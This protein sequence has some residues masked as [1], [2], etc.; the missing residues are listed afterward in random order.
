MTGNAVSMVLASISFVLTVI[1]G[2][3]L[4][5]I[6]RRLEIGDSIRIEAPDRHITKVGTPTMGGVMFILPVFLVTILLNA[7]PLIGLSGV[8]RS[9]LVPLAAM[10]GFALLGGVDDWR[11]LSQR[12]LGEGMRART[13]FLLQIILAAATAYA[14]RDVLNVPHLLL[15]GLNIE[16]DLGFWFFPIAIFIIVGSANA[17]NFTDGLDGLA[18]L[19]AATAFAAFGGIALLQGQSF[20]AQF[21]FTLVGALFGF[22]WFN[23]FPAQLIMGDTGAMALGAT[24]GVVALMTGHWILLPLIAIIPVSE[25]LSVILQVTFFRYTGGRRILKMSPIHLH[26][27]LS[28]WSET[29]IVLRFWLIGLLFAMVGV[30]MAVV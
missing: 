17:V 7:V 21:C 18:G 27:E 16:F 12:Q 15:P 10:L 19:I 1:W 8:G 25:I 29:Q 24:L 11:K 9:I 20:L 26:F 3:P 28:G 2:G 5:R 14:L 23:V 22:L 30:A 13:K 4:I 6:L